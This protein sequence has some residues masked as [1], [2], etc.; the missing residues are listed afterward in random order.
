MTETY[1]ELVI[2]RARAWQ[3]RSRYW[4]IF[5]DVWRTIVVA[6]TV[7]AFSTLAGSVFRLCAATLVPAVSSPS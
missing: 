6:P 2:Q 7:Y 3:M 1:E 5:R 4:R